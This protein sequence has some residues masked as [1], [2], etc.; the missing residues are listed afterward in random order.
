MLMPKFKPGDIA[1]IVE[2]TNWVKQVEVIKCSAGFCVIRYSNGQGGYRV[3]ES[4]LHSTEDEAKKMTR[5]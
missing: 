1:W 4:R 5:K 2:S 3:R